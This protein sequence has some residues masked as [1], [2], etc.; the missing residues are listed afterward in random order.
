[1]RFL[2]LLSFMAVG[3]ATAWTWL[4]L[5]ANA[6]GMCGSERVSIAVAQYGIACVEASKWRDQKDRTNG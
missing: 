5:L 4:S 1:M 2:R 6:S 3:I